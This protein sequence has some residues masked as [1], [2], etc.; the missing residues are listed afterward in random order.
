MF[1]PLLP[2]DSYMGY[3][4][5]EEER[6]AAEEA[7]R[8]AAEELAAEDEATKKSEP[9]AE[10]GDADKGKDENKDLTKPSES[11][12][13]ITASSRR[14]DDNRPSN[15]KNVDKSRP[16]TKV[17]RLL[18][19]PP[20]EVAEYSGPSGGKL[21]SLL[22]TYSKYT[23][24]DAAISMAKEN[25]SMIFISLGASFAL[26]TLLIMTN[27][28]PKY[29]SQVYNT[30]DYMCAAV[31]GASLILGGIIGCL[32][33]SFFVSRNNMHTD[34]IIVIGAVGLIIAAAGSICIWVMRC[35]DYRAIHGL[36]R[37]YNGPKNH[38]YQYDKGMKSSRYFCS[39]CQCP[40][41]LYDPV[42]GSDKLTYLSACL[43]GC[44]LRS[45]VSTYGNC[46]CGVV[47]KPNGDYAKDT[48]SNATIAS[49]SRVQCSACGTGETT[50]ALGLLT[51]LGSCMALTCAVLAMIKNVK[52]T[53]LREVMPVFL[54][55]VHSIV[56]LMLIGFGLLLEFTCM[57]PFKDN[58]NNEGYC[59]YHNPKMFALFFGGYP[60]ACAAIGLIFW[61]CALAFL[62][63]GQ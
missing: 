59:I 18:P 62:K 12:Q 41:D 29:L 15:F 33:I 44:T 2:F 51:I 31:I 45:A 23:A 7:E 28:L 10:K 58:K 48:K 24:K 32:L 35:E 14:T 16:T 27:Y 17:D 46:S 38:T 55:I 25:K 42:C 34:C 26:S 36:T 8:L 5:E 21:L 3:Y 4:D 61:V 57:K 1:P 30:P 60:C 22:V 50:M 11:K 13:S 52:Y 63:K 56:G 54:I 47:F 20:E 39:H 40:T 9:S 43:A 37:D 6:L 19:V 49:T 53:E